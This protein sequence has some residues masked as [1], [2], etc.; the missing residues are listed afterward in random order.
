[1]YLRKS[2]KVIIVTVLILLTFIALVA[3]YGA[4]FNQPKETKLKNKSLKVVR[5]LLTSHDEGEIITRATDPKEAADDIHEAF[6]K[7]YTDA[8]ANHVDEMVEEALE[9]E[10]D[11]KKEPA[12]ITFFLI[13]AGDG[14]QFSEPK[15][16]SYHQLL[17]N[18]GGSFSTAQIII[19]V[20]PGDYEWIGRERGL[21]YLKVVKDGWSFKINEIVK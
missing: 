1:M 21:P 8:F 20:S 2:Q 3:I 9:S 17:I 7:Y 6:G 13:H 12:R 18:E 11:F 14:F 4:Y 19:D 10:R 15:Y 16:V 5:N